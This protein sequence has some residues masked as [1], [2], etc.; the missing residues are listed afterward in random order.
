MANEKSNSSLDEFLGKPPGTIWGRYGK[1]VVLAAAILLLGL[2]L[3]WFL[4]GG[5]RPAIGYQTV[6]VER[7]N[8]A[9]SVT[10]VGNLAPTNQITVGSQTS[11]LVSK[12]MA[13]VN[14]RVT[15]DQA[16]ASI[17]ARRLDDTIRGSQAQV[18]AQQA[19]VAQQQATLREAEAQLARYREVSRLSNGRVP[20]QT[21]MATQE[22]AVMRAAASLRSAEAQVAAANAA[23][24]SDRT[25]RE[26]AVIR[27]PVSGVILSRQVDPG[28]TVAASFNTPTLFTIAED[29]A[30]MKL[31]VSIDEADVGQVKAGQ[32]ATFT[33]D[34]FPGRQFPAII[35]RVNLGATSS[36][37]SSSSATTGSASS[38]ISYTASLQVANDDLTLRPGMTA[39]ATIEVQAAE[40][41]LLVPNAALRFEPDVNGNTKKASG[42]KIAP[43]GSSDGK[44]AKQE[45]GIG[46]GSQQTVYVLDA[47]NKP[48]PIP[49][50]TGM[51]DG[52]L[53]AVTS[54]ALKAGAQVIVARRAAVQ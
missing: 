38:V 40:G 24:S 30:R 41:V 22:A 6:L 53:T 47:E 26:Y 4:R 2:F 28:Q 21:E 48:Q 10:A 51:S 49:V 34:A 16:I 8:L 18:T 27:S 54:E 43:P 44:G 45:R 23:L 7:G 42:I 32:R 50:V 52:R 17:D 39:T 25:Q 9:V 31:D 3:T 29:L 12:V 36:N 37:A 5:G 15:A 35:T 19:S 20:S 1:W 33:V 13:D 11:G 46:V 14:D